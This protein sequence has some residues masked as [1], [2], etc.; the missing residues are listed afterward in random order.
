MLALIPVRA[1]QSKLAHTALMELKLAS[2]LFEEAAPYGGRA[3][4]MLVCIRGALLL[5]SADNHR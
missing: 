2:D 1:P 3:G 5:G 4:K